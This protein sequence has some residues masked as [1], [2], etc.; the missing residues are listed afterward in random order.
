ME[1]TLFQEHLNLRKSGVR[2][3]TMMRDDIIPDHEL[4]MSMLYSKEL[5]KVNVNLE[6]AINYLRKEDML[7]DIAVKGWVLI[8]FNNI[9]LGW[10][11]SLSGR[12]N[13]YYPM[14]WRISMRK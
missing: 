1:L 2:I 7:L 12:V 6:Q 13:N 8:T 4:A 3:G 14:N 9:P 11:K 10:V 5:T